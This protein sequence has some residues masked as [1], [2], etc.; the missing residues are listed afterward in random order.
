M[1]LAMAA[2]VIGFGFELSGLPEYWSFWFF[3]ASS[4]VYFQYMRQAWHLQRFLG[5]EF[6]YNEF[7]EEP[8]ENT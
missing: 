3:I 8:A 5:R 7:D 1:L 6:I 4:L 2:G